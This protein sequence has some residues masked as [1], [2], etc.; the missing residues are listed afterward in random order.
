M[1]HQHWLSIRSVRTKPASTTQK[2]GIYNL[3]MHTRAKT[4]VFWTYNLW[5]TQNELKL[6]RLAIMTIVIIF[7]GKLRTRASLRTIWQLQSTEVAA[8]FFSFRFF[9]ARKTSG[10]NKTDFLM[11]KKYYVEMLKQHE[12]IKK[13]WQKQFSS[14]NESQYIPKLVAKLLVDNKA[15]VLWYP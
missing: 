5:S 15:S 1:R 3:K 6:N 2:P 7:E 11:P 10:L 8:Y 12:D 4:L 9:T 13:T 14:S